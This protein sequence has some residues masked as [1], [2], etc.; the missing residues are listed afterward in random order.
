MIERRI[1]TPPVCVVCKSVTERAG[2]AP[3]WGK[4][5]SVRLIAFGEAP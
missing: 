1:R 2:R 5:R 4:Q 3:H